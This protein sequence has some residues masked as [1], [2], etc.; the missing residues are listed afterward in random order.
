MDS[1]ASF[2]RPLDSSGNSWRGCTF[3]WPEQS[4][5]DFGD[6]PHRQDSPAE[7]I[8][9]AGQ[10]TQL[11]SLTPSQGKDLGGNKLS[12]PQVEI[13]AA[14]CASIHPAQICKESLP[15]ASPTEVLFPPQG[16]VA[17]ISAN[18]SEVCISFSSF[19]S[20]KQLEV[21]L[22]SLDQREVL[23]QLK[24][25]AEESRNV[26]EGGVLTVWK[27]LKGWILLFG[28]FVRGC[29]IVLFII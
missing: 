29:T 11:C 15:T 4:S 5:P 7:G 21:Y 9:A 28:P 14:G 12:F 19:V 24:I 8:A 25:P 18:Q 10:T 22:V 16:N 26:I 20:M 6:S 27:Y 17:K 13:S 23:V 3:P 2:G 1:S